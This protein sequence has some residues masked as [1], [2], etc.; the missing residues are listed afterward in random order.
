[1]QSP[2]STTAKPADRL[3]QLL[4]QLFAADE[5][6]G[7]AFLRLQVTPDMAMVLPLDCV[8]ETQLLSPQEITPMPN[9]PPHIIGLMR[10]RGQVLWLSSLGH[11]LGLTTDVERA[12][13]YETIVIRL[14][15][16]TKGESL[17]SDAAFL[18]LA[19]NQI[20]GSL[21]FNADDIAPIG[22]ISHQP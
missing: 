5:R 12:Y 4:P 6:S 8:E 21:R 13:R 10:M 7:T 9:M 14:D 22:Q 16:S 3:Q 19:V 11:L 17:D 20:K 1:M 18:G 15:S 2:D